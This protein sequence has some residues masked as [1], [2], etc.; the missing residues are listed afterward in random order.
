MGHVSELDWLVPS[1]DAPRKWC[2]GAGDALFEVGV[3]DEGRDMW[4]VHLARSE[5]RAA[6]RAARGAAQRD[7][8]NCAEAEAAMVAGDARRAAA[9]WG[10]VNPAA[11]PPLSTPP[12]HRPR[13]LEEWRIEWRIDNV[14]LP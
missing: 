9:L 2:T 10:K 7:A 13:M 12:S 11:P 1:E 8:V 6:F 14:C 4:A 5:W 3:A